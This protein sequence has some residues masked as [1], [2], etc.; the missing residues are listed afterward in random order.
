MTGFDVSTTGVFACSKQLAELA[1]E[2]DAELKDV[3]S[4]VDALLKAGWRGQAASGFAQGWDEWQ[5]GAAQVQGA[6]ARMSQLLGT[7][8]GNYNLSDRQAEGGMNDVAVNLS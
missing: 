3:G 5:A 6:L 1:H 2:L 4:V 7:A 8:G